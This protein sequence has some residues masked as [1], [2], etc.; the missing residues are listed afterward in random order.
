MLPQAD[1]VE[2]GVAGKNSMFLNVGTGAA[3]ERP[4]LDEIERSAEAKGVPLE[5]AIDSYISGVES[6]SPPSPET[7]PDGPVDTPDVVIDDLTAGQ[8]ED[9]RAMADGEGIP[10]AEAIDRY[11]WQDQFTA[12]AESLES[13]YPEEF[14]G[15]VKSDTGAWFAFKGK[16]PD[17]A[18]ELARTIPAQVEVV[19]NRGFSEADLAQA[20]QNAHSDVMAQSGV[21]SAVS[22]YD[23]K[24]GEVNVEVKLSET[25][26]PGAARAATEKRVTSSQAD[27]GGGIPVNVAVTGGGTY[28]KQDGYTR[29]GGYLSVGCTSGFNLKYLTSDVKRIGTAGHCTTVANQTYSNHSAQGGST[30]V[31]TAWTHQGAWGDLGYTSIGSL[32]S[33]RTFY[34]DYNNV[35]YADDRAAMPAVGTQICKFG[36]TSGK[37]CSTVKYRDV[38]VSTLKHM[39]VMNGNACKPGDSGGPWYYGGTAYGIHTGLTNYDGTKRCLFTPAYLFQNRSYDVWTR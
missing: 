18:V 23:V 19:S 35:R 9:I 38:S 2:V 3:V 27:L 14:S 22:A 30:G 24:A 21:A 25:L 26:V 5:E 36:R 6:S 12:V 11:G 39:V 8:L 1:A 17:E 28:E 37:T 10:L 13:T 4:V 15:A 7:Q 16:A 29:G 32:A 34:Q 31:T 33:S 20:Q